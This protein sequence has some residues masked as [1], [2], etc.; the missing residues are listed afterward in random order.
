MQKLVSK[1][2]FSRIAGV[3][4]TAI[5]KAAKFSLRSAMVGKRVD[6][7]HPAAVAVL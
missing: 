7:A 5:T 4:G 1:A 2:E 3:S 6:S